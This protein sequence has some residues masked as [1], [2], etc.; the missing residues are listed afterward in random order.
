VGM[1]KKGKEVFVAAF[2]KKINHYGL[3]RLLGEGN[4]AFTLMT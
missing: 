3:R 2:M 1:V 4:I